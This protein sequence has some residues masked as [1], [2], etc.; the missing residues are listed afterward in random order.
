MRIRSQVEQPVRLGTQAFR[1]AALLAAMLGCHATLL[2]A[3]AP[4]STLP[5]AVGEELVYQVSLGRLG[6]A[7][8]GTMRVEGPEQLRGRDTYVL[9]FD[10]R[11]RVGPVVVEDHTRSW[12]DPRSMASLRFTKQE[13]SPLGSSREE[14]D[15]FPAQREWRSASGESGR[16]PTDAPLDELSFIYHIR[17]MPL[18]DGDVYSCTRHY[19]SERNPV[20]VRV[21]G[22]GRLRVPAGEFS[23]VL[24]E[25]RVKDPRRY[26]K[27]GVIRLH[28]S[29]DA[30]RIP[31]RI[32]SQMPVVGSTV[33]SLESASASRLAQRSAPE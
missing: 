9:R 20:T 13:R 19:E 12:L 7:G 23:T 2:P 18:A 22:R 28:L 8:R 16:S 6:R 24:V 30:R 1:V 26:G 17:A 25:M 5:F 29:D 10:F 33:L 4:D 3:Q 27:E 21:L 31:I 11:G 14:V 15:L 32:E